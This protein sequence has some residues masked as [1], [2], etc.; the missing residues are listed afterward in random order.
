MDRGVSLSSNRISLAPERTLDTKLEDVVLTLQPTDHRS[1]GASPVYTNHTVADKKANNTTGGPTPPSPSHYGH[2]IFTTV[3]VIAFIAANF[4]INFYWRTVLIS[5]LTT[6]LYCTYVIP[7]QWSWRPTRNFLISS[8]GVLI[9][10][11]GLFLLLTWLLFLSPVHTTSYTLIDEWTEYLDHPP[12]EP[13]KTVYGPGETSKV[14]VFAIHG[15][16]SNPSSAWRHHGN[17]T[18]V[19]WLEDIL[20]KQAGLEQIRVTTLNHQTRW[21]S[22]VPD[23]GFSAHAQKMLNEIKRINQRKRPIV[24]IAHSFG[25]LLLKQALVLDNKQ[26]KQVIEKTRG[27][28]FLAVPHY[29]TR[30]TFLASLL[31]CTAYWRGSSTALLEYMSE[32]SPALKTLDDDFYDVCVR[33][34]QTRGMHVPYIGNFL[35]MRPERVRMWSL[36]PTVN[37]ESGKLQYAT[38]EYLDADHRGINKF[39]SSADP[40]F[41]TFLTHFNCAI[42]HGT[43]RMKTEKYLC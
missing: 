1:S 3:V 7:M 28:L 20:P 27:I 12:Y 30:A 2:S 16:G 19:H 11:V 37:P 17:E 38:N 31:S 36:G 14:D 32:G 40:N 13:S 24:F 8:I 34:G 26:S 6:L 42:S 25:G 35:E 10:G 9:K 18:D 41:R 4:D 39:P 21:D 33:P 43:N 23:I 15:L 5:L 22:H 29:G